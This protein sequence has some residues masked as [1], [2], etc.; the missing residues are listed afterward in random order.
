MKKSLIVLA[1]ASAFAAPAAFAD[2]TIYGNAN[3]SLGSVNSGTNGAT[4]TQVS[5]DAS[6]IGVKGS[7]DLG[8]GLS[9]I[10]QIESYINLQNSGNV[11]NASKTTLSGSAP[12]GNVATGAGLGSGDSFAG[13]SSASMGTVLLGQ[14][15]SPY[16]IATR[17]LDMFSD[18][19]A[20]NRS[21]MGPLD[22]TDKLHLPNVIAYISPSF[23]GVTIAAAYVAGAEIPNTKATTKGSA[24]S[25]AVLYGAGPI[26]ASFAYQTLTFGGSSNGSSTGL[27]DACNFNS[28]CSSSHPMANDKSTAWKLGGSYTVDAFG[29]NAV[30]ERVTFD[31]VSA[32]SVSSNNYYI[33]GKYNFTSSDAVKLAYTHKGANNTAGTND[34]KQTSVG[35]DHS[36]SKHT[37]VYAL[38][39]K[40]SD[41]TNS[42]TTLGGYDGI[43]ATVTSQ[44]NG[45]GPSAWGFGMKHSF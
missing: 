36:L 13:L 22:G 10:F 32:N 12:A 40:V 44:A 7:E 19:I 1:I 16:K 8:G 45:A 3:V 17:S 34:A 11:P 43:N 24:E 6:K 25:L 5:S 28:S 9:A 41:D 26:S 21:L 37:S 27:L 2:T 29:V 23:S 39:T 30:Y 42:S 35:Y 4:A 20:D 33:A 18:T 31:P 14:H 38:Y 15:D